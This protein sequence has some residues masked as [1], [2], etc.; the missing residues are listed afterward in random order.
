MSG[1]FICICMK[2]IRNFDAM[3]CNNAYLSIV[4]HLIYTDL[5]W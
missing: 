5:V 1:H 4:Y 3:R 2:I